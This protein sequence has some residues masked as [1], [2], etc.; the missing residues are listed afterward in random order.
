MTV[1]WVLLLS[2]DEMIDNDMRSETRKK[3]TTFDIVNTD[4]SPPPP[5]PSLPHTREPRTIVWAARLV[6]PWR[7]DGSL[8]PPL[9]VDSRQRAS[10]ES[11]KS[12]GGAPPPLHPS[13]PRP[14]NLV[15]FLE[16]V[17]TH[18]NPVDENADENVG[19][20][21]ET[22][23]SSMGRLSIDT[24]SIRDHR[25]RTY[26]RACEK[27]RRMESA[28]TH[29]CHHQDLLLPPPLPHVDRNFSQ[30]EEASLASYINPSFYTTCHSSTK[31]IGVPP[32]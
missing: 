26:M 32:Y 5:S 10:S 11:Q 12:G 9:T 31:N 25:T 14:P 8:L 1:G 24:S 16:I 4:Q 22:A 27:I 7:R 30:R 19:T 2:P 28:F 6:Y 20:L 3:W 13:S 15:F 17:A 18:C 29:T 23:V 21:K